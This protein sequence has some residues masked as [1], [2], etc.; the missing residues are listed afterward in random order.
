MPYRTAVP[1]IVGYIA[2][3]LTNVWAWI[4]DFD[5]GV[6][7]SAIT[8]IGGAWIGFRALNDKREDARKRAE[9]EA[10]NLRKRAE[11]ETT[12]LAFRKA[13]AAKIK[14]YRAMERAKI[15]IAAEK[16]ATLKDSL[17]EQL[18]HITG[19]LEVSRLAAEK[20]EHRARQAEEMAARVLRHTDRNREQ[21]EL[22]N[23]TL[24]K[25]G[26][27][28]ETTA[29]KVTNIEKIVTDKDRVSS[30]E[31]PIVRLPG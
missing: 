22:N 20:A 21:I 27:P 6:I 19:Q 25:F 23:K 29:E 28:I 2:L 13:E 31:I 3:G 14:A 18:E 9:N 24:S 30:G 12:N 16:D 17:S 15:L 8:L 1:S 10:E 4:Q 26:L 7:A 5:S 11:S